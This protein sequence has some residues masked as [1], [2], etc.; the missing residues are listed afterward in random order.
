MAADEEATLRTFKSYRE[1]IDGLIG[2]HG[3]RIF[4]T[5]GGE[6]AGLGP[7]SRQAC[8]CATFLGD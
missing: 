7:N 4:G 6:S 8:R 5:G 2:K 3:G 1:I